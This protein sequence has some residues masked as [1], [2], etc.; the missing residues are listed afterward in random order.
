MKSFSVFLL[1]FCFIGILSAQEFSAP[2]D[3]FDY[4]NNQHNQLVVKNLEYVQHSVHSEDVQEVEAKRIEVIE[5]LGK[6]ILKVGTLPPYGEDDSI[7]KEL[8]TV[9]KSYLES[10]E[11]EFTE[12]NILKSK[13]SESYEAMQEYLDAQDAAEKK[14]AKAADQYQKAQ[15]EFAERHNIKLLEAEENSEINQINKVNA[16]YRV[17]FMKYFRIS[18]LNAAFTDAM[19]AR[20]VENMKIFR[21]KLLTAAR[22]ELKKLQLFPDFNGNTR[23]RDSGIEIVKFHKELAEE[24]YQK[25]VNIMGKEEISQEDVNTY[26]AIINRI[27]NKVAELTNIYN[28]ELN[29]L[30][31]SNVPKPAIATKRI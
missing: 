13:S 14:L 26:N 27:N 31:R 3:Y 2:V 9:L 7:R 5:Q 6:T 10:F 17:V 15:R 18:K 1:S 19:N 22:E 29:N 8:L 16:Y 20:D 24:D 25:M 23:F 28:N 11:I 30:L 21:L 12:I 4:L